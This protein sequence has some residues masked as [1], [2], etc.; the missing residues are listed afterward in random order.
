MRRYCKAYHLRDLRKFS[1]W[2]ENPGRVKTDKGSQ[3]EERG[4]QD[5]DVVFIQDPDLIVT[6][7]PDPDKD[8][9]FGS[10]KSASSDWQAYCRN[11]LGWDPESVFKKPPPP[12]SDVAK[13]E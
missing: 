11:E 12:E 5:D 2:S 13:S 1:G 8:V 7:G 9:I 6:L 3:G 4:L 10:D